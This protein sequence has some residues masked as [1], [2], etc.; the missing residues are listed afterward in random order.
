MEGKINLSYLRE[1][2]DG[3]EAFMIEMIEMFLQNT[4]EALESMDECFKKQN[5]NELRTIAHRIKPSFAFMG[6]SLTQQMLAE[7]ENCSD[8]KTNLEKIPELISCIHKTSE[9]AFKALEKEL[10]GLK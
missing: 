1:V 9:S 5:W 8:S 3:N 6:L 10:G 7:I 4:P 2:S